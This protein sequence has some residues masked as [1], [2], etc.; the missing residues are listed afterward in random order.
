MHEIIQWI[1]KLH[2]AAF[3]VTSELSDYLYIKML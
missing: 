3:D 2:A 1:D